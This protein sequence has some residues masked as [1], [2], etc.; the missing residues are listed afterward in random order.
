MMIQPRASCFALRLAAGFWA[1]QTLDREAAWAAEL[2]NQPELA[3]LAR[4]SRASIS[5]MECDPRLVAATQAAA[6]GDTSQLRA[7]LEPGCRSGLTPEFAK[8]VGPW[9]DQWDLEAAALLEACD[10]LDAHPDQPVERALSVAASWQAAR[11]GRPQLF[12]IRNS[13][14]PI[15]RPDAPNQAEGSGV[16]HG[17]NLTDRLCA[18][19][20]SAHRRGFRA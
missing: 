10:L 20:L 14:Y 2:A 13:Y 18:T 3:P 15:T 17:P 4:A 7:L 19:A 16:V 6:N 5:D 9:L 12:G 8:E 11:T 1:D